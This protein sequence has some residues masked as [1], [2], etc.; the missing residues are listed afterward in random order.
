MIKLKHVYEKPSPRDVLRFLVE[1]LWPRS[2]T[3]ERASVHL[4]LKEVASSRCEITSTR[5]IRWK[6]ICTSV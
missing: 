5:T 1:R 4:C 2:F 3:K 6:R